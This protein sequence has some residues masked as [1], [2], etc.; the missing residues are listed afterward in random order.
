M[1][2]IEQQMESVLM[3]SRDPLEL[4]HAQG[5]VAALREAIEEVRRN[6]KRNITA[7]DEEDS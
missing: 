7:Q 6:N 2:M 3:K 4:A 5:Y 1:R